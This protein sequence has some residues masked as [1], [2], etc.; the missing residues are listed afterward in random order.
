MIRERIFLI[1]QIV[2]IGAME[3]KDPE[4]SRTR[5][6]MQP[7]KRSSDGLRRPFGVAAMDVTEIIRSKLAVNERLVPFIP[8]GEKD[9]LD[10]R[11]ISCRTI[12][13]HDS[14]CRQLSKNS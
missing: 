12:N 2:R 7:Q 8:C 13:L 10:V 3:L 9:S 6:A 5:T 14:N 4:I 11:V 1:C